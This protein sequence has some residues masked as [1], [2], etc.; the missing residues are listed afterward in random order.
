MLPPKAKFV[1]EFER[2]NTNNNLTRKPTSP[3]T[4]PSSKIFT[5]NLNYTFTAPSV[6]DM[7]YF[8]RI[9]HYQRYGHDGLACS[10]ACSSNFTLPLYEKQGYMS[11]YQVR[12]TERPGSRGSV[13]SDKSFD[14]AG[15]RRQL[16]A[17][18]VRKRKWNTF[19]AVILALLIIIFGAGVLAF[20]LLSIRLG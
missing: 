1:R 10:G 2:N 18:G 11:P 7:T 19:W 8:A 4:T 16:A 3:S 13:K 14:V 17:A 12:Y 5:H 9:L 15:Y 6:P 20:V